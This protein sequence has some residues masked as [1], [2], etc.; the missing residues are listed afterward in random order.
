MDDTRR[1]AVRQVPH[2]TCP[3]S[4]LHNHAMHRYLVIA[5]A[6]LGLTAFAV[7]AE[8]AR[9]VYRGQW[10]C[11]DRGTVQPL[12]GIEL[13]LW[14]RGSDWFPVEWVGGIDD[15]GFANPDGTF[16]LTATDGEDTH[17]VRMA[18]RDAAGV[19][20]K[21]FWGINDWSVDSGGSRNNVAVRDLGG[22]LFSTPGQSHKCSVW[23]GFHLAHQDFRA[24]TGVDTPPGGLVI[25]ADAITAGVPFTP[26]TTV[27]WPG[28]FPVGYSGGGDDSITRHEF[29]HVIRHGYDGDLGHFLGDVITHGYLR[30]HSPCLR[31]GPGFAFNEGWAEYWARDYAPAPSCAG[32]AADDYQVEGNVAAA[33]TDIE[34]RCYFGRRA[35]MVD[36]L[37]S[38][39]GVIHS[40]PEFLAFVVCPAPVVASPPAV[41]AAPLAPITLSAAQRAAIAR[42]QVT[43]LDSQI[44]HLQVDLRTAERRAAARLPAC[45]LMPCEAALRQ[46]TL[47]AALGTEIALAQLVRDTVAGQDSVKEQRALGKLTI[48]TAIRRMRARERANRIRAARVSA[49]GIRAALRAG[50]TTFAKDKSR[51]TRLLRA[52]LR[53]RLAAFRTAQRG[54]TGAPGLVLDQAII[55]RLRKVTPKDFPNPE[56]LPDARAVSTLTL[57]C[58]TTGKAPSGTAAL[59]GILAAPVNGALGIEL[60]ITSPSGVELLQSATTNPTG[61]YAG[62]VS[63]TSAGTWTIFARWP[64]DVSS[65][66][67][68]SPSCQVV[69]A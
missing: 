3:R 23:R 37:R 6:A 57:T 63:T 36:I 2:F 18:L 30:N 4:P 44:R 51:S 9:T 42:A 60:H 68:D 62:S 24:L 65:Q 56:P 19:H 40:Y 26:H 54:A 14:R 22:L 28:G 41:R 5:L 39:P 47:P 35:S 16:S 49:N 43:A 27:M 59:S 15:R 46:A 13:Q 21:D 58:P 32:F 67:D 64:G 1:W 48:A 17:F 29:G 66:P 11:D 53:A 69:V 8:A 55:D 20:L 45:V 38:H 50:R 12:G 25:N 33:L 34:T 10:Q 52:R 61:A 7:P 31:T